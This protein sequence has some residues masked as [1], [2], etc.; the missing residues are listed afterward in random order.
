ML[1]R[2]VSGI[3]FAFSLMVM[4]YVGCSTKSTVT[5]PQPTPTPTPTQSKTVTIALPSGSPTAL[6]IPAIG[7]FSGAF[8]VAANNAPA[9]TTVTLTSYANAP[10]GAPGPL[11]VIRIP[12]RSQG[13]NHASVAVGNAIFWVSHQ[14]SASVAFQGFPI[15]TWQVPASFTSQSLALETFDGTTNTLMDTEFDTSITGNVVQFP[16]SASAFAAATGHTY[17]WE[18]ISGKPTPSPSPSTSPSPTPSPSPL[19]I[20]SGSPPDGVEGVSYGTLHSYCVCFCKRSGCRIRWTG[21]AITASGGVSPYSASWSSAPGSAL[22][23]GLNIQPERFQAA[24]IVGT[25]TAAGTYSFIVTVTDSQS[26]PHHV[27]ANYTIN[28]A[29]PSPSPSPSPSPTST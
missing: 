13:R 9:G 18:L 21:F 4:V 1:K 8:T 24:G 27:S 14:Y 17:W 5:P 16:G 29:L 7:G 25:P 2:W 22:P 23:P 6:P 28:V 20:T 19:L 3:A 12:L 15:T 10:S 26:P 11:A